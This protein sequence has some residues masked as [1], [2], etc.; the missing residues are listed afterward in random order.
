MKILIIGVRDFPFGGAAAR[1]VHMLAKGM[2]VLGHKVTVLVP[3]TTNLKRYE[4]DGICIKCCNVRKEKDNAAAFTRTWKHILFV[5][6]CLQESFPPSRYDWIVIY[7]MN[8]GGGL[9][10]PLWKIAGYRLAAIQTDHFY[11]AESSYKSKFRDMLFKTIAY[12]SSFHFSDVFFVVSTPL[13]KAF[14]RL[15]KR[16][17]ILKFYPPVD[18]KLFPKEKSPLRRKFRK[19][20]DEKLIVFSGSVGGFEGEWILVDAF[21][22]VCQTNRNSKLRLIIATFA[23]SETQISVLKTG[24]EQRNMAE[25]ISIVRGLTL[26]EVVD[27]LRQ[28]DILISPKIDHIVNRVAMPIKLGEYLATGKP[29]IITSVG[30]IVK[31]VEDRKNVMI[32]Q[33]GNVNSLVTCIETLLSDEALAKHIGIEGRALAAKEFDIIPNAKRI[34]RGLSGFTKSY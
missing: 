3:E 26:E 24:I 17:R 34:L 6:W 23:R 14:R 10:S 25:N 12:K 19:T 16:K 32:A 2:V 5:F 30:D 28:A 8:F 9:L 27:L 31:V 21:A 4:I 1:C 29:T 13:E 18:S 20:E 15:S 7:G 22:R 11:S 33:P